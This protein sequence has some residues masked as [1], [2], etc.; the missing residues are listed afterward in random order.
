M[1]TF[2]K[3][4]KFLVSFL[5]GVLAFSM[6]ARATNTFDSDLVFDKNVKNDSADTSRMQTQTVRIHYRVNRTFIDP[7]YMN[8]SQSLGKFDNIFTEHSANEIAYI[9]ITG[10]ASPEGPSRNNER[11]AEQRTLALKNHIK[12]KCPELTDDQIVTIPRGENWDGLLSMIEED[13]NVPYKN[14]LLRILRSNTPREDQKRRMMALRGGEPYKYLKRHILPHLRGGVSSMIY[15]KEKP[16]ATPDTVRIVHMHS[17]YMER[18][19][20]VLAPQQHKERKPFYIALKTNL[21][22]DAALLPNISLEIPFGRKYRWSAAIE[23]NWSWWNTG[24]NNSY[25]YSYNYHRIQMGGVELR[26]WFWNRTDNP[27]NGF[28]V[29]VYGY[30]GDYDIRL[31]AKKNND[32]GQQSLLSYSAGLTVGYAMPIGR[33]LN[34]E[35]GLGAGYFGGIYRKYDVSDCKDGAFPIRGTYRRNYFGL[36]KAN[37]SL[38][39]LIGSGVNKDKEREAS[40]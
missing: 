40:R 16:V 12:A 13:Q 17:V 18:T 19:V 24:A 21:L 14:E 22:Y 30:A 39:W 4:S 11:L 29:G 7:N 38:V 27:L 20:F 2:F 28:Y 25:G 1:H 26:R 3:Y 31:F 35:F 10:C 34:L 33:R 6:N 9:V 32:L 37:I 23:G 15:F 5:C 36:T 8:N